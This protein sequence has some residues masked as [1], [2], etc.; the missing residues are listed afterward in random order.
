MKRTEFRVEAYATKILK[1]LSA[2]AILSVFAKT[3]SSEI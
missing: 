3:F 2:L 1:N